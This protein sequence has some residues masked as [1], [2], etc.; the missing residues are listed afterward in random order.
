M[1][2]TGPDP[3]LLRKSEGQGQDSLISNE[4][5]GSCLTYAAYCASGVCLALSFV[6]TLAIVPRRYPGKEHLMKLLTKE[7][8]KK[9]PP[10]YSQESLGGDAIAHAK[11]FTPDAAWN[12]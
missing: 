12:F 4:H 7:L 9:L 5:D 10:L 6:H 3:P 8:R 2:R 11:F 1:L